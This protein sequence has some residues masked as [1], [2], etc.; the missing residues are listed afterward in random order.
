VG[1]FII[2]A[3]NFNIL[4][5]TN[6]TGQVL[7]LSE[8]DDPRLQGSALRQIYGIASAISKCDQDF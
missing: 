3:F 7:K 8:F 2:N 4:G 1:Q 6:H 5:L